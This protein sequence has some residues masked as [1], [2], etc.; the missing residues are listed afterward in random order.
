MKKNY[1]MLSINNKIMWKI[2]TAVAS[3]FV[4]IS[5]IISVQNKSKLTEQ[6][7]SY[8]KLTVDLQSKEDSLKATVSGRKSFESKIAE[9]KKQLNSK[10]TVRVNEENKMKQA[11]NKRV[12]LE[13]KVTKLRKINKDYEIKAAS[14]DNE[15]T[16]TE[17][18]IAL[19]NSLQKVQKEKQQ[20]INSLKSYQQQS[21]QLSKKLETAKEKVAAFLKGEIAA[22][23]VTSVSSVRRD[24][25]FVIINAG[26]NRNVFKGA[27]LLV[28]RKGNIV[29]ELTVSTIEPNLSVCSIVSS[30]TNI[31][32][33]D[34]VVSHNRK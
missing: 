20:V 7:E 34:I 17:K 12:T 33:G 24:L 10:E 30:G 9:I 32:P 11:I 13:A 16:L 3:V 21:A 14:W 8:E 15:K 27:K 18:S 4:L 22:D 25:G 5:I 6:E 29:G 2:F 23:F 31:I 26:A 28:K 19:K 1:T